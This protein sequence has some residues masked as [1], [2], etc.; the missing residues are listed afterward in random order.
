LGFHLG[1]CLEPVHRFDFSYKLVVAAIRFD[2]YQAI[3]ISLRR[4]LGRA[5][6]AG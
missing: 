4:G 1:R 3:G 6:W 5:H 2:L